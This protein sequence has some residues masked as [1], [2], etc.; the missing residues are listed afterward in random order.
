MPYQANQVAFC[1]APGSFVLAYTAEDG[2]PKAP[3][4]ERFALRILL[5]APL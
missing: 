1:P 4:A 3:A 2:L 5:P